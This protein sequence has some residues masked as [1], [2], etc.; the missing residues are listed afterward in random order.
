MRR[1]EKHKISPMVQKHY[2][3]NKKKKNQHSNVSVTIQELHM[4][5]LDKEQDESEQFGKVYACP[6]VETTQHC[7]EGFDYS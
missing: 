1:Y 7:S 3:E 4:H 2:F 5:G 6:L